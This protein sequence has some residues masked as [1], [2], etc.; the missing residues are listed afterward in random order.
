MRFI[1]TLSTIAIVF[2]FFSFVIVPTGNNS[3]NEI[4]N[5]LPTGFNELFAGSGECALCHSDMVNSQGESISIVD[6]WRS[7]MKAN[8]ARD[9][10]WRAKVSHEGLV[11]PGH[12]EV[13]EDVCTK[14]HAPMGHFNAHHNGQP[15]YSIEEMEN[16]PLAM[17]GVSCTACHQITDE[18]LGIIQGI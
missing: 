14:C 11:N 9:P 16:D 18:S 8:A 7:S 4:K 2:L 3:S 13:L 17:D 5:E 15:L 1:F 10:F 6:D 12:A